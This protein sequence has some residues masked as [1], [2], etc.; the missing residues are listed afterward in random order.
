LTL[1]TGL[2]EGKWVTTSLVGP[3][4]SKVPPAEDWTP[5]KANPTEP[6]AAGPRNTKDVVVHTPSGTYIHRFEE[7]R[8]GEWRLKAI[9]TPA[10]AA[11][12]AGRAAPAP[13]PTDPKKDDARK[14]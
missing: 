2:S 9:L 12:S 14:D 5:P 3:P 13:A 4:A 10:E 8:P 6:K 1:K 11:R 7:Y